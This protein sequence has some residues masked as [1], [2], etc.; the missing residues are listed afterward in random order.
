MVKKCN[1]FQAV[2]WFIA[3]FRSYWTLFWGIWIQSKHYLLKNTLTLT[4][5]LR[6]DLPSGL[7]PSGFWPENVYVFSSVV[8]V[9]MLCLFQPPC[10]DRRNNK[11]KPTTLALRPKACTIFDHSD[12]SLNPTRGIVVSFLRV[13]LSGQT[14]RCNDPDSRVKG[15]SELIL[16]KVVLNWCRSHNGNDTSVNIIKLLIMHL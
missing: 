13:V 15:L 10:F 3:L 7:F 5:Y 1:A 2:S 16:S 4:S 8:C 9:Y 11:R 14:F 6:L 12:M